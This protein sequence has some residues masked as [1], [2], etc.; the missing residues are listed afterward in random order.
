MVIIFLKIKLS[1]IVNLLT[2]T[3]LFFMSNANA[4]APISLVEQAKVFQ[5]GFDFAQSNDNNQAL[6]IWQSLAQTDGLIP[7]LRRALNNNIA[8]ILIRQKK[9]DEAKQHLD[10][11]L[12]ADHQIATTISN[13]NQLY[14]YDAQKAYQK[15][16]KKTPVVAPQAELLYFDV[17]GAQ[18]PNEFV[19]IDIANADDI[20]LVQQATKQWLQAWRAQDV[21][22]Y[23][24]FY[25]NKWFLPSNGTSVAAWKKSRNASLKGPNFIKVT[26]E[27]L[28]IAPVADNLIRV[29]FYQSYHSDRFKD[30]INKVLLWKKTEGEWKI[31]QEVKINSND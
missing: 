6:A 28:Q 5:Q 16:F 4:Q 25:D 2:A 8:V 19:I 30:D 12:K 31:I 29:S 22:A 15:I 9:Y 14:A 23:L 7:Q 24:S 17:K 13:L 3:C 21:N 27:N 11:A 18:I 20:R 26:I 10:K 1:L